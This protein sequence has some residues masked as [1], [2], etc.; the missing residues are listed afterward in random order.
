[1]TSRLK[2]ERET[3]VLGLAVL[4]F[5]AFAFLLTGFLTTGNLLDLVRNV[6]VLGILGIGMAIVIIGRGIDLAMV[7]NMAISIAWA[8]KLME[9]GTPMQLALAYGLGFALVMATISGVLVAYIE[10]PA[11]FATLAMGIFIYGFGHYALVGA[12][13]VHLPP[14]SDAIAYFG[15]G[16]IVGVPAASACANTCSICRCGTSSRSAAAR[17]VASSN[18]STTCTSI[19]STRCGS[20]TAATPRRPR[21][22]T[23]SP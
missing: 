10:V 18:M 6:S 3:I 15:S 14:N 21:P 12:D 5:A 7:S 11:L 4:L 1:M 8:V 16:R 22:A 23:P 2:F 17:T 9:Q 19:S 13:L 20:R